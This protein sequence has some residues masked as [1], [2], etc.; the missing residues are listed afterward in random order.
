MKTI[1]SLL[2]LCR[3]FFHT[4]AFQAIAT[5]I[6]T[7][8]LKKVEKAPVQCQETIDSIVEKCLFEEN[9]PGAAVGI[10]LDGKVFCAKGYGKRNLDANL[11]VTTNTLFQVASLSKPIT[12]LLFGQLHD[13]GF[14]KWDDPIIKHYTDFF[15]KDK[16]RIKYVTY[17]LLLTHRALWAD[18]LL[19]FGKSEQHGNLSLSGLRYLDLIYPPDEFHYQ[20]VSFMLASYSMEKAMHQNYDAMLQ[21]HLFLPLNMKNSFCNFYRLYSAR[22]RAVGY[23]QNNNFLK[24]VELFNLNILKGAGAVCSTILDMLKMTEMMLN[25]G[26]IPHENRSLI[27]QETLQEILSP[28]VNCLSKDDGVAFLIKTFLQSDLSY[29][30]GWFYASINGIDTF[31]HFGRSPGFS[32]FWALIP[33][34]KTGFVILCNKT[35]SAFPYRIAIELL[36][37]IY[38]LYPTMKPILEQTLRTIIDDNSIECN[39]PYEVDSKNYLHAIFPQPSS[40]YTHLTYG[41][42]SFNKIDENIFLYLNGKPIGPIQFIR[43]DE[44]L[45]H[46]PYRTSLGTLIKNEQDLITSVVLSHNSKKNTRHIT[47]TKSESLIK[48]NK[49]NLQNFSGTYSY[50]LYLV[51]VQ[52]GKGDQLIASIGANTYTLAQDMYEHNVFYIVDYKNIKV[53]FKCDQENQVQEATIYF[54]ENPI[55]LKKL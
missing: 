43:D 40:Q 5:S 46:N 51:D 19:W 36:D 21:Q 11:P 28:Q 41:E 42:I 48:I 10:I 20:N 39:N 4:F 47:F 29:A 8:D 18:D 25:E 7:V 24:A 23:T 26:K 12:T 38:P 52:P 35:N 6:A 16:E 30:L 15:L 53:E 49:M 50:C 27:K 1:S 2:S 33:E 55:T 37:R 13:Q 44:F 14:L 34:G 32:S 9:V 22:D 3:F 45:I 54:P 31:F 17:R